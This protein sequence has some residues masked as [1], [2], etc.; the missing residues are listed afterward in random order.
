MQ[1]SPSPLFNLRTKLVSVFFQC[2]HRCPNGRRLC[3][4]PSRLTLNLKLYTR[5][6]K[7]ILTLAP[8]Y[9]GI[10]SKLR[11][12][13]DH[14]LKFAFLGRKKLF[15]PKL[16]QNRFVVIW[17]SFGKKIKK[18]I[19]SRVDQRQNKNF[20]AQKNIFLQSCSECRKNDC[21]Q[22]WWNFFLS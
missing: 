11:P 12:I 22:V 16:H 15:F 9:T 5:L 17:S 6:F 21:G 14:P 10:W 20:F 2:L 4:R 7:L 13:D 1:S 19:L 3:L 18:I 8:G